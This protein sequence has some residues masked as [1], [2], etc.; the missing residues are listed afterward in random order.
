MNIISVKFTQIN[1]FTRKIEITSQILINLNN[2]F[3]KNKY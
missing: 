1:D 2:N 3:L